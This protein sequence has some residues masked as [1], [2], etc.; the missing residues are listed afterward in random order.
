M[1]D[2]TDPLQELVAEDAQSIDRNRLAAFLKPYVRFDKTTKEPHFLPDYENILSNDAKLEVMLLTSKAS[3]LIFGEPEGLSPVEIIRRDI[4][5]EGS[6]KSAIKRLSD[7]RKI[8]KDSAGKYIVPNYRI[9][10][11]IEKTGKKG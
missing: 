1:S 9:N 3:S 10:D 8:K 11:V 2:S 7:S 5:P 6:V 4:M